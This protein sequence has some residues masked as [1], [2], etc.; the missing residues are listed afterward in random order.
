MNTPPG[1]S[2]HLTAW[3]PLFAA[4]GEYAL[5]PLVNGPDGWEPRYEKM[6]RKKKLHLRRAEEI[7]PGDPDAP[8]LD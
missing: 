4:A 2:P 6:L 8:A 5:V 1:G 7:Q 3:K